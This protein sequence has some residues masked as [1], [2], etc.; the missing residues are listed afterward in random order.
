MSNCS[1]SLK[2]IAKFSLDIYVR[3]LEAAA[4][5]KKLTQLEYLIVAKYAVAKM[6]YL[7]LKEIE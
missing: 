1:Q 4:I 6:W 5:G 3:A 2:S 7:M